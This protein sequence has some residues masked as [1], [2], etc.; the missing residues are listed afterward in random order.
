MFGFR[1][2]KTKKKIL[3]LFHSTH[4]EVTEKNLTTQPASTFPST[5][6]LKKRE[7]L[8]TVRTI[9]MLSHKSQTQRGKKGK[10]MR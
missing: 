10:K 4:D 8:R 9:T 7:Q 3:C 2:L 1:R 5:K 6:P